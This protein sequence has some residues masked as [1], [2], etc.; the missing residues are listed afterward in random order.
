M[1]KHTSY[2]SRKNPPRGSL[3]HEKYAPNVRVPTFFKETLLNL[4]THVE[5]HTI[6]V[7]DFNTTL[8]PMDMSL[9]QKLKRDIVKL[10]EVMNKLDLRD[11]YRTLYPK[12]REHTFLLNTSRNPLQN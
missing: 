7:G 8:S 2:S 12:T 1:G 10:T 9:K 4:K 5:P 11:I 3:N 6:V